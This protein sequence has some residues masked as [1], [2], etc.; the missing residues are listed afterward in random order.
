MRLLLAVLAWSA[1]GAADDKAALLAFKSSGPNQENGY[2][3]SWGEGTEPCGEGWDTAARCGLPCGQVGWQTVMCDAEG[4]RVTQL[5]LSS[6][7]VTGSVEPLAALSQLQ[8]LVVSVNAGVTGSVEPLAALS[9]LETLKL[10]HTNV[11]GSVESLTALV[12][13]G[14]LHLQET[15]VHGDPTYIRDRVPGLSTWG[16]WGKDFTSCSGFG[17]ACVTG[18]MRVQSPGTWVGRN[19]D[20]CCTACYDNGDGM[21]SACHDFASVASVETGSCSSCTGPEAADCVAARCADGFSGVHYS[22]GGMC[23]H[24]FASVAS[25]ETGSCSSCTGPEAADC[26]EARCA[27]GFSGYYSGG[28][29]SACHDFASVA[30]VET[31][32][33][34]S[35]TGPEAADCVAARCADG[36]SGYYSGGMCSVCHDF[37]SV[38]SVE[39]GSCSS[40]TGPEAA[41]CVAARCADGFSGYYSGGG[42][43]CHDFAS[44]ASVETGSCSSCTGPEA[45]DCVVAR[46]ADGFSGYYS[47]GMCSVCHDFASVASV[48]TG[49]CSSCTGPEAADCVEARCYTWYYFR[50]RDLQSNNACAQVVNTY[51]TAGWHQGNLFPAGPPVVGAP[52]TRCEHSDYPYSYYL[53]CTTRG[54]GTYSASYDGRYSNA[55]VS[56]TPTQDGDASRWTLCVDEWYSARGGLGQVMLLGSSPMQPARAWSVRLARR[57]T[58]VMGCAAHA[59]TLPLSRLW[60]LALA[61]PVRGRRRQTA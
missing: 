27:D 4:G 23:C 38:A 60:R 49:S 40:C 58:T 11:A 39:T 20:A 16:R 32:S 54:L 42:M 15:D 29:C 47:G 45:A 1:R 25:V 8:V 41:D 46:C 48:E 59:M 13:L 55:V 18:T 9:Q 28:M 57:P 17:G 3:S 34:S 36:F 31:G 10:D 22:G 24:D 44:V 7:G 6:T 35:C 5:R 14:K 56:S 21:C 51:G 53:T 43:C 37:A 61:A 26:V 12:R 19:S 2:L 52:V 33:C 50:S 30:S